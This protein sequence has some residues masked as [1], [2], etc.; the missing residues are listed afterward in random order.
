MAATDELDPEGALLEAVRAIVGP[1]VPIVVSLDLHGILTG[2]RLRAI[3]GFAVLKTYPHVDF[4]DTGARAARL[5][6]R[7]LAE[8]LRPAFLRVRIP[9]LVRGGTRDPGR[10]APIE[11]AGRIESLSTGNRRQQ[12]YKPCFDCHKPKAE[13]DFLFTLDHLRR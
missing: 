7:I 6:L 13:S 12:D 11:R 1:A 10:F 5:L 9:A 2:R 4:A 8:G 3:D